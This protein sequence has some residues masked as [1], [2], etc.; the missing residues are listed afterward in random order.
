MKLKKTNLLFIVALLVLIPIVTG[1]NAASYSVD[2]F[3]TPEVVYDGEMVTLTV[4]VIDPL[5]GEEYTYASLSY[6]QNGIINNYN[7]PEEAIPNYIEVPLTFLFG[8]FVEGDVI[9][10]KIYLEFIHADNYQS[11]WFSFTVGGTRPSGLTTMQIVYICIASVVLLAVIAIV[12]IWK[13][14]KR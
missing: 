2:I 10:Y 9:S 1:T 12:I 6:L 11:G 4:E 13:I 5:Y 3:R 14:R 7:Y 8:P